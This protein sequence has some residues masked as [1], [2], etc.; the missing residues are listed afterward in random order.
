[1]PGR[2][3]TLQGHHL[4]PSGNL[5]DLGSWSPKMTLYFHFMFLLP[6]IPVSFVIIKQQKKPLYLLLEFPNIH[7]PV[8]LCQRYT[9]W[10]QGSL[11][12]LSSRWWYGHGP[13]TTAYCASLSRLPSGSLKQYPCSV[14]SSSLSIWHGMVVNTTISHGTM[15]SFIWTWMITLHNS[16][17]RWG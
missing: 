13:V 15:K 16:P 2:I 1:M 7:I 5:G 3:L 6:Y 4:H 11:I 17:W 9:W 10:G 12:V 14:L 8:Q